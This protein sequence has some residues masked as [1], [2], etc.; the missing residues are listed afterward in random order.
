[1]F[2]PGTLGRRKIVKDSL[3][4]ASENL[5]RPV[6]CDYIKGSNPK[7]S[8]FPISQ[9]EKQDRQTPTVLELFRP[10]VLPVIKDELVIELGIDG[11]TKKTISVKGFGG[12]L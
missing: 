7:R 6:C 5:N 4:I 8:A 11:S 10:T 12:N 9:L 3:D 1:L 2:I